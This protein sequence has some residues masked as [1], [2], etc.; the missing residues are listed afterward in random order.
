MPLEKVGVDL[1]AA[2]VIASYLRYL[3]KCFWPSDLAILYPFPTSE[4]SYLAIWQDWQLA[5]AVVVLVLLSIFCWLQRVQRPYLAF[6]WFWYVITLLPVIGIVQ[7][8]GQGMADRYTYIPLIGPAIALVWWSS[9]ILRE[10]IFVC[11]MAIIM[12]ALPLLSRQ[13]LRYWQ[14]TVT[15]FTHTVDVTGDNL[16]AQLIIGD[17]FDRQKNPSLAAVHYRIAISIAPNDVQA[18]REL[19]R[20]LGN[21]E[22]WLAAED[23]YNAG[24]LNEPHD[25]PLHLGLAM[26]ESKRGHDEES[27]HHLETALQYDPDNVDILNNLAW[28]LA[29]GKREDLRNGSRAV[30]LGARACALTHY[31]KTIFIG[32]LA[33]AYAEA[34]QFD[35]AVTTAERAV[36]SAEK[37]GEK[38]LAQRNRELMELYRS[39]QALHETN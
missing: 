7:V 6:G 4:H 38:E 16:L 8:G 28:A 23:V 17:G 30:T 29:A 39:H 13:Q 24:L 9:E 31:K 22:K 15:L 1:R 12:V 34:G 32:T 14:D 35:E 26:V 18:Y 27:V 21:Q 5:S 11:V 33:A 20:V 19:G 25:V 37:N 3:A 36:E 2:N 10:R